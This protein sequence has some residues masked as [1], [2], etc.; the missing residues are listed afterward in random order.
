MKVILEF[1]PA[2]R[3]EFDEAVD[4]YNL[5]TPDIARRFVAAVDSTTARILRSPNSFPIVSGTMTRRALVPGF[6]FALYFAYDG[7]LINVLSVFHTSR[8]PIIW[9]G[10]ID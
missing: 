6:P 4:W 3:L 1:Q 10:R 5:H 9:Q 7:K 2:A 8:N